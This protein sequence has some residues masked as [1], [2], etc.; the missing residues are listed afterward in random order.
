MKQALVVILLMFLNQPIY[1]I[2]EQLGDKQH[3]DTL[4]KN[5]SSQ[6]RDFVLNQQRELPQLIAPFSNEINGLSCKSQK[7]TTDKQISVAENVCDGS[8]TKSHDLTPHKL[9]EGLFVFV[10]FSMSEQN[11]IQLSQEA[12]RFGAIL[13]LRG[14]KN[15]SF[16]ET[17]QVLKKIIEKA[18]NGMIIDPTLFKHYNITQVPSFILAS[19]ENEY[20]HIVGNI[21]I[22]YALTQMTRD[23]DLKKDADKLL[24]GK[25]QT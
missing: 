19:N 23:G 25:E 12:K 2:P 21:S 18:Q 20:D 13:V 6:E 10:S 11:I 17:A 24:K 16:R 4:I 22:S 14:L 1:A 3:V 7:L 9:G 5:L 15:G 8:Q